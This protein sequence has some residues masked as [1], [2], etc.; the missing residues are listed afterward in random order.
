MQLKITTDYAVRIMIYLAS[1]KKMVSCPKIASDMSIPQNYLI[2]VIKML[3][4]A[5]LVQSKEGVHGGYKLQKRAEDIT[6]Y[7][8]IN[9]VE[10]L[11]AIN[12]CLQ[13]ECYCSRFAVTE[14]PIRRLYSQVQNGIEEKLSSVTIADLS[15]D[16]S[17]KQHINEEGVSCG[18]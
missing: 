7:E 4:T 8:V 2:K 15:I 5:G 17:S 10:S 3:M 13:T 9:A 11:T 12:R 1:E 6:V 16:H 14:C 18:E